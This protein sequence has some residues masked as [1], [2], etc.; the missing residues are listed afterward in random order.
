MKALG[1]DATDLPWLSPCAASLLALT[2]PPGNGVWSAVRHDPGC[3]LLLVRHALPGAVAS[4][5]SFFPA[6]LREAPALEAAASYLE[7]K[8]GA[9]GWVAWDRPEVRPLYQA[10]LAYA[11]LACQLAEETDRCAPDNAWV[12]GLLASLGSLALSAVAGKAPPATAADPVAVARRLARR[13]RL[14]PWLAAVVGHLALPVEVTQSLG[15]EPGL[16]QVVQLAVGLVDQ[17]VDG[18][19]GWGGL[20]CGR[21]TAELLPALHLERAQA[22]AHGAAAVAWARQVAASL[23]W[24]PPQS[25]PLLADLLR[26]AAENRRLGGRP[27]VACL[28]EEVDALAVALEEQYR[29]EADRLQAQ[30]LLAL[31]ELAAGAGHEINNPLAVISGQ[32]QYLLKHLR[33]AE[34]GRPREQEPACCADQEAARFP[35]SAIRHSLETIIGQTQRIHQ[36]LGDLMQFARPAAPQKQLVDVAALVRDTAA[37]LQALAGERGVRL[38]CQQ[39]D[40]PITLFADPAQ[41]ARALA[42]LLRNAVE[43]APAQGWAAVSAVVAGGGWLAAGEEIPAS[44]QPPPAAHLDLLVEDNGSGPRPGEAEHLFDP[45][46]SGRKAGRGRGLGLPTAWR[47]ARQHGGDVFL[48]CVEPGVT[49][50]VLRLPLSADEVQPL[51]PSLPAAPAPAGPL[52][53]ASVA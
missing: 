40:V 7:S 12:A 6:L 42:C 45:F 28:E 22:E 1:E 13:W 43:A 3:V 44:R 8:A 46:Y 23:A 39:P 19:K 15:A 37:S 32:A 18:S 16:F 21:G 30:K 31:A 51:P 10:A 9:R 14:P 24:E 34:A 50:F 36:I 20:R 29:G 17:H 11:R 35:P 26:L 47:L 49:R 27:A 38:V 4:G 2:R 48:D 41:L 33:A 25:L 5:L 52:P 53:S